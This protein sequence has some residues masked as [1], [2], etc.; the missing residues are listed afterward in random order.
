MRTLLIMLFLTVPGPQEPQ[1]RR[2]ET[3][4]P[5]TQEELAVPPQQPG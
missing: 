1:D 5:A 2:E 3:T 4:V